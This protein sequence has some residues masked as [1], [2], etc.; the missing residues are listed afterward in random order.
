MRRAT[1]PCAR[2]SC[3]SREP[4]CEGRAFWIMSRSL[5]EFLGQISLQQPFRS[6]SYEVECGKWFVPSGGLRGSQSRKAVILRVMN[7]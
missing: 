4:A 6:C 7:L 1:G 3:G 5:D 2:R